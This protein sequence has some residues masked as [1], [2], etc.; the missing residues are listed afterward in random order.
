LI[1]QRKAAGCKVLL[2]TASDQLIADAIAA[3]LKVFDEAIGSDGAT[4]LKGAAKAALLVKRFGRGGFDYAGDSAADIPVWEAARHAYAVN[5][6]PAAGRWIA[7]RGAA[8]VLG[9]GR[10]GWGVLARTLRRKMRLNN[11]PPPVT[12]RSL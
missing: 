7:Q 8:T 5:P 2:V 12:L 10:R 4:N 11:P 9:A 1:A 3:H 6:A